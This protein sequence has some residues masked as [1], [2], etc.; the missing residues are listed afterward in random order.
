MRYLKNDKDKDK[1]VDFKKHS[2]NKIFARNGR[3]KDF[4][5]YSTCIHEDYIVIGAYSATS[6]ISYSGAVYA[7]HRNY[8]V[9][10]NRTVWQQMG[11][12]VAAEVLQHD[13]FGGSV[14]IWGDTVIVGAYLDDGLGTSAGAAYIFQLINSQY[15]SQKQRLTANDIVAGSFFGYSVSIVEDTAVVGTIII[16]IIRFIDLF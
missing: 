5:G 12:L 16:V 13:N 6:A 8:S 9:E 1:S 11:V 15:W 3:K 10:R 14:S 4:F 7:F 2:E